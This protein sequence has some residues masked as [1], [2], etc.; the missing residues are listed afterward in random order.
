MSPELVAGLILA[1]LALIFYAKSGKYIDSGWIYEGRFRAYLT[2]VAAACGY[3]LASLSLMI[4]PT[5]PDYCG[6]TGWPVSFS[7]W[8]AVICTLIAFIQGY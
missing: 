2:T 8:V 5:S 4:P 1:V 7:L 3:G 6:F